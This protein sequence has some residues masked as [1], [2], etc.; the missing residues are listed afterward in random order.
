MQTQ[1]SPPV[2]QLAKTPI[3]LLKSNE[4]KALPVGRHPNQ[5]PRTSAHTHE[6]ARAHDFSLEKLISLPDLDL[7]NYVRQVVNH[8]LPELDLFVHNGNYLSAIQVE[9]SCREYDLFTLL[10]RL[11]ALQNFSDKDHRKNKLIPTTENN[12]VQVLQ[13]LKARKRTQL[14]TQVKPRHK[15]QVLDFI[16]QIK[17]KAFDI[18]DVTNHLYLLNQQVQ[19]IFNLLE[20]EKVISKCNYQST[21]RKSQYYLTK[22]PFSRVV[23]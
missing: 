1:I 7:K 4:N 20:Y 23:S 5:N 8:R 21:S 2:G 6:G 11:F 16:H 15:A 9:Y 10:L 19:T 14:N 12:F 22:T 17:N 13:V 3:F 18:D